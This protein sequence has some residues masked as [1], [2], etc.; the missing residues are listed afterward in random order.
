[1]ELKSALRLNDEEK[2]AATEAVSGAKNDDEKVVALIAHV[3][4][5][6]RNLGDSSVTA[7]ERDEFV[8]RYPKTGVRNSS[9]IFRGGIA[10]SY[11]MNV[12]FA[13]LAL[14]AGMDAR[15]ALVASRGEVGF[16]PKQSVP[17]RY[18]L[19]DLVMAAKLG[20]QFKV[21]DVSRKYL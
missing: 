1:N 9:E 11:E 17:D 5:K 13:A 2:L 14:Q 6:L 19:D 15:P 16:N 4:K 10:T 3:R 7:A 20:D 8:R 21:F 12:A 18:F